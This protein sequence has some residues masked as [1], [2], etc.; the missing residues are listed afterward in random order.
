MRKA[1][2]FCASPVKV[3]RYLEIFGVP[4]NATR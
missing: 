2:R 4:E 1:E 3:D